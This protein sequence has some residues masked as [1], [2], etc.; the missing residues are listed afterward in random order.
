MIKANVCNDRLVIGQQQAWS[1]ALE[2]FVHILLWA[3]VHYD[4]IIDEGAC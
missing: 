2:S 3:A 4:L 1:A